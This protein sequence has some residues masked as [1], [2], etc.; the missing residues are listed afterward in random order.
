MGYSKV[1]VQYAIDK[2][3]AEKGMFYLMTIFVANGFM[4]NFITPVHLCL[5]LCV[6]NISK[7]TKPIFT[8]FGIME[9]YEEMFLD[10]HP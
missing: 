2:F 6:N 8:K 10:S 9:I 3:V 5:L 1:K 4:L 7:T